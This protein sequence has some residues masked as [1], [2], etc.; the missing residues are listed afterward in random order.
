MMVA[1]WG[2]A[3]LC[4]HVCH[5]QP[6]HQKCAATNLPRTPAQVFTAPGRITTF[7]AASSAIIAGIEG[8]E[9]VA[10]SFDKP[11]SVPA[12]A[13]GGLASVAEGEGAG[14]AAGAKSKKKALK[15]PKR[16]GRYPK[17]TTK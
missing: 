10:W 9:C 8:S 17:R 13:A 1:S 12:L 2:R 7:Q 3:L 16:Q 11:G 4:L 5:S 14:G 15:V 6:G